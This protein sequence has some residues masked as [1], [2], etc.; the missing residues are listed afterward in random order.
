[1]EKLRDKVTELLK[2]DW[3]SAFQINVICKSSSADRVMRFIRENPPENFRI[4]Q[5]KKEVP[6]GYYK[7]FEYKLVCED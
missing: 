4:A 7:C 2:N 1:M 3:Y 5:R 6:D